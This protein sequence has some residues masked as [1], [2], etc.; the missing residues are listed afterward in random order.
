MSKLKIKYQ[1]A[2]WEAEL[3][4][5]AELK[6]RGYQIFPPQDAYH[7]VPLGDAEPWYPPVKVDAAYQ[8]L[9][10]LFTF[11]LS[12]ESP[13]LAQFNYTTVDGSAIAPADYIAK[14]GTVQI[15]PGEAIKR[16]TVAIEN[17][18]INSGK[19]FSLQLSNALNC[20]IPTAPVPVLL[21]G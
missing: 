17:G 4:L 11:T 6:P 12:E 16:V 19:M 21:Y 10:V 2:I 8:G 18:A 13:L 15:F 1:G 3:V 7:W 9:T 14:S 5:D 20:T